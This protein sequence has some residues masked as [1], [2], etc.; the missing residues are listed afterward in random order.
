MIA[1]GQLLEPRYIATIFNKRP[2]NIFVIAHSSALENAKILK[3]QFPE[4]RFAL[5]ETNNAKFVL[6]ASQTVW[7][8]SFFCDFGESKLDDCG[9][10]LHSVEVFEKCKELFQRSWERSEEI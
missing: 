10:G 8:S 1:T 5:N 6:R 9:I 3:A 4:I 2:N 7:L